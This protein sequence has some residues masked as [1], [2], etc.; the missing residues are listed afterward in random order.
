MN[1]LGSSAPSNPRRPKAKQ[2][3]NGKRDPSQELLHALQAMRSGDFSVRMTGDHLGIEG[4]IADTFNEIVAANQRMAQQLERVGQVVGREGKTR[5]RVKFGL[6]SGSW[7]DMEGSVNTL[8][9]DLLWPTREVTRAVAAVAQGDLLQT[10]QLDVDGRPLG[11]EFLQSATIV[12]TMIKQLSVFTSEVTRVAR[13]V[14]TEGKLGGQAQVPEV[15]GVWKDLTESVNSMANNLT[16]QVRNIAEVTIA[17]ANGDLSKKITVDVRGEILQLKEAINTMVDQLRSFASEVTR[18]AREVGTDGKLGGQAIVP[19]VAGTWKD[20][21]DSV[22]AMCGNLTAQVRNIANVTTAVARGDLSRK[23]TVD[24]RGEI[25]EL[26][27]TINTMVDQLNS[28]ASEVTRVAR[29]VGT[30]GKLG[31][32]AQ[33]P[34]VAGTWKDLT[35]NVNFMASNLTAQV[36]N[37][38]DV[39]TA[40]AG[41]D[42][43][44]KITVNV[45]GEILQL[46]ETLN[47]MVDQLNAFAGEVTRVAREVGTDGRLGGQ[48][49]V[50]GVA[51]TWKDLTE[52]VN[53]MASNLTAQVRNI[54]EVTT[55]VANGDLSKKITV[56][57]RGEILELKDTINTMVDQLNAFAGEVTRV[58][59]E[60]GTEGKLGGQALVRG[61]AGTWKDLTDS[62]N[63][64][65]SNLTGQVRNIAE[66][67]TA[68]AKGDLSKKITVNVSGEI[69]Q[70]KETLNTM[71]DQLNA[72]AG[73][74]T[75]VAREVGTDGKLGGQA[76]VPGVAGTWKDLTDS[77][78]SMAGNLTAQ[79]RNIAEVATAIAGGDL[80]RKITVDVRGEILQ[81]KETLNTMVD[82]LNRF[83]GEVTRVAREVGTEGRLGGQ[84][85]VPGVAGTWK[86]L[87]D[88]VNSMAGNLTAQ[89]RNIAEV[90]TA[91]ARGDL[92]R[93]ITV[94]VKGEI[95]ELKNTIN[96][97]VDQLNAFAS[98]VTRVAREVGTEGKLGGQ[99]E[100]PEVAGTW[101]DLTDNVNFMAS[102]LTA[103]VRNIAEVATAIAGGDLSKKITVDVRGEILLLKDTLNTMVE[104]LRSFAAEVTRVAREVGTEGRLGGQAVV[105]GVGGT[106]KDLTD[107][108]NL[109]AANLTTQVRN[110]AEVTTAV[111]R[112]DLSRKITVDVKGEILELKNTINTMVDQLNA[113][114]GEVTRVAREVGTEGKLGGQAQVPGVAGTWK[115]LTDTVNFMAANLTEQVR[116]IVKVVTAVANGDLKQNLTVKSKGEVAA[117]ADTINNMTETLA[118]FADQVTSVAR[119]VGVEGR[120]GGQANVPGAAGTWKDLTGNVNLLAAN[121]TSQVRAIAEVATA[122]TKGDLTRSIQVEARG[123]VAELKDNINTMIGNLRLTTD[124]NTEQDW[125]KT[126]LARFTNML[127]GQRDLTTVGRLLLTELTPLVN[128]HMG[129]IY[130]VDGEVSPQLRLLSAY[131]GDR[132][133]PHQQTVQFGE[134][135]IGQCA[136]DKR[137]RLVSDIPN[138]TVPINSALLRVAPKN[139]VVLPVLFENQVKAVIELAS[140]SPFTTSQMTFL[141]Q[142]TDSIGIVLNSIEATMQTEGLLKQSQQL[143][144]ELQTQQRELQQTNEQ[145]EQ[146]AQQLAERN[147]EVER[148]N[149]EI[150]QARRALEEK[151]TELSLTS[152]YKSEF[153]ANMS[154]ELRTPLNSILILG[155]QLTEN[156]DG[157]LS[158]KQVE[159]ARTIHGAGTDLLNLI[160]D[161]L[162]LSKIESG[163]VTVDAQEILTS[164][165]LE[166]VGRPFRHEA[167][168]RQLSFH[169]DVDLNLGRSIVTDS[170]RLQQV[171]KNL[172]SNAF[173]FTAEGGV[174]LSVSA[175]VGGWSAEHPVLNHSPA[176]VAFEVSDTGIGIP[177]EKQKLIF[178]AF[179][180]ADAGTSRKYGGTGL[181]LAIS[182]E[183]ANLL[184]GEIHLQSTPGKGS[185]FT[186]YLPLKYSG[187]TVAPRV[188][189]FRY[190]APAPPVAA[191]ERAIEQLPDDRLQL[192]P[193]DSILL[194][195]EDDQH[196]ARVLADLARDKGFKV[197]IA[198]SGSEALDLAKQFQPTAVSLD[199]FLPDMLGWTVLS[200]L[201]HNPLTRHIPVQ[202]V[203][204]DEDRQHALAR[205]AFAFVSKP[206]TT[207][208]VSAALSRIKE[209]AKPRRKRLLI[210]EDN[211]AE[212]MSIRE[213]LEHDDIEIVT[214]GTGAGALSTLREMPCDCVVLDL[215]LP[216]MSGFEVLDSI[217]SDNTLSDVPVVVFTGRE[218]SLEEETEL[219]TMA[220]SIVVKGVE[221]PERLLDETSLFLHRVIT[222]LPIEKQRMLEKLNGSDEDLVG[223]TALLVDDDARNIFALSSVLERRGMNVLAATTGS[224]AVAL[225]ESNPEI[226]IILM[227]I[228]M[229]QMD[230]YQTIGVIREKPSFQ[231]LPIIA[232]TAKAMKGDREKCLEAGASDYLAKPVNTEELLLAIRM[233]LHR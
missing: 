139:L 89:V 5:Q 132:V 106:W 100:V 155:Q 83:A 127:Q 41:G 135:L 201:K 75:R 27:D 131:A 199:V 174:R 66:V 228:M 76:E 181:G 178:E 54:A 232:L 194:I 102:N 65:A 121:L 157:N 153:L 7:A 109:L 87:T 193:G 230:G 123:E 179:Q 198:T 2:Y 67:A 206:T 147:V 28:F 99:A 29:E 60:V 177:P 233:W 96:T 104:Q 114:A 23:I 149:Q 138:D 42:L 208:G 63:S 144:G 3:S 45:S 141:E 95:L 116:G 98:E 50:L 43:S 73:E 134:G 20:L 125:L 19:G 187:P 58:A 105:P 183:L 162:D 24:V 36:R 136:M 53:S 196:Y 110:I 80:S 175:A 218:L 171:L 182:R 59:R 107:N 151:A 124:V 21:T 68:V 78:N 1:D 119:E 223:R 91:V 88:S 111:A 17:V 57:V 85:N 71:V 16:G 49:N 190:N 226:A 14:G 126:N 148:K 108:V 152:K 25:L 69:L 219:H 180:Q 62:V 142:L 204:L 146:K 120:L 26:K 220:R 101:K 93:K 15:T 64:M 164:N 13:E 156:P 84:A 216:D 170:K 79:V 72:F 133:S 82:Q 184:G 189:A 37:I 44:K 40:I 39:A 176:V 197:L 209:Y 9:D 46:K 77:V 22:N 165:L 117:L 158:T 205:G 224:E 103:Q 11:G 122:V 202:I 30:E 210:V 195:V 229:P 200:Q 143:A 163:T 214:S 10:V 213:L 31:G 38:A 129:V 51:G 167:E 112:G 150:E 33:V 86:D 48:A 185:I 113:F 32:Q 8:I 34:G 207:E 52:S 160:S 115:D 137:H 35:D 94:D 227:D 154:H 47:T 12:N 74:V 217:R 161:I 231:R 55:A 159:F 191:Q 192:E 169:V 61:V 212:Q 188:S 90:T 118:T 56:D 140:V 225:A 81:L 18:V 211:T 130:Q 4:K 172:L 215:R 128:A 173:K 168:N 221:S 166:T 97:M 145:L 203:T 186:L 92:S 6:S 222:E 70:L